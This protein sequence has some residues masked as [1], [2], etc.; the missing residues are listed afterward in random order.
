M[1]TLEIK[2]K[3]IDKIRTTEDQH[4]LEEIY[5][6]I[7][8]ESEDFEPMKLSSEQKQAIAQGQ[9]DIKEGKFL[10]DKE[11]NDEIDQWLKG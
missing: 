9:K 2:N 5:R 7:E 1:S 11:A 4:L 10:T 8:I 6:L 3:L